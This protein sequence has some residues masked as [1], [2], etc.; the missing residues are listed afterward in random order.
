MFGLL[1]LLY[2]SCGLCFRQNLLCATFSALSFSSQQRVKD[3]F[4]GC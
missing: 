4:L 1:L 2:H 3:A